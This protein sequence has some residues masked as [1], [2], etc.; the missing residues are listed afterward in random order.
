M[1]VEI[2]II[3]IKILKKTS[4]KIPNIACKAVICAIMCGRNVP[5]LFLCDSY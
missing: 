5:G 3:I 4:N 1:T 2:I